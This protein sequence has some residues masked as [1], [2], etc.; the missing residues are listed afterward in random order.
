MPKDLEKWWEVYANNDEQKFFAGS[1]GQS[2][3]C[4]HPKYSK[5]RSV[6]S[7][8]KESGLDRTDVERILSKYV[9][10]GMVLNNPKDKDQWGYWENVQGLIDDTD[11]RSLSDKDKQDRIDK[12]SGTG[13]AK[14]I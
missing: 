12:A 10:K 6:D 4:R 2:G 14:K 11:D 3:L 8:V 1:D 5:W 7:L 13:K 9:K